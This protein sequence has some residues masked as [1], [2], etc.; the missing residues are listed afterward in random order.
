MGLKIILHFQGRVEFKILF[1]E[2]LLKLPTHFIRRFYK[3]PVPIQ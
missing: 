1:K 3:K 2:V